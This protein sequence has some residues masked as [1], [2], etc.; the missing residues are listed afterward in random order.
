MSGIGGGA[1]ASLPTPGS[2]EIKGM[3]ILKVFVKLS[4]RKLVS[5]SN[6]TNN[7]QECASHH[8]F[9]KTKYYYFVRQAMKPRGACLKY[10]L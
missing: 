4:S 9:A 5:I 6:V 10:H 2:K 3:N 1:E 7:T 8:I